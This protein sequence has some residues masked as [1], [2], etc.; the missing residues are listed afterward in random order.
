MGIIAQKDVGNY[1]AILYSLDNFPYIELD[2][3]RWPE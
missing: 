2:I 3:R 1:T